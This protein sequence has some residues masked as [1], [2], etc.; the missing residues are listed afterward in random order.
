M[1]DVV[2]IP[3]FLDRPKSSI[4]LPLKIR[5]KNFKIASGFGVGIGR[6]QL[7]FLTKIC[8]K[9]LLKIQPKNCLKLLLKIRLKIA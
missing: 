5:L 8:L 2:V 7:K 1:L 6:Q 4:S 3:W 9:L